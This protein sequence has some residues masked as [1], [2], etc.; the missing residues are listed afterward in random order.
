[1]IFIATTQ[2]LERIC[3]TILS[4]SIIRMII[5]V[6]EYK[7]MTGATETSLKIHLGAS[8]LLYAL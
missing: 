7:L 2:N 5:L 3:L 6:V 8:Q 4:S 1:M